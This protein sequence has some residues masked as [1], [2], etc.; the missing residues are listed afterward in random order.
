MFSDVLL[1]E[2]SFE[3]T[4]KKVR[5]TKQRETQTETLEF[6]ENETQT[7]VSTF[8]TTD[9]TDSEANTTPVPP[10]IEER[11]RRGE[12]WLSP[13]QVAASS[14]KKSSG[15]DDENDEIID[16]SF[17]DSEMLQF[18]ENVAPEMLAQ[19]EMNV[20]TSAFD[21]YHVSWEDSKDTVS[22]LHVLAPQMMEDNNLDLQVT[23]LCWNC[24]G[25]LLATA[26]GRI[27]CVGWCTE[28][29]Y[30]TIWNPMRDDLNEKKPE[31]TIE[32]DN[33]PL[34]LDFHPEEP[35]VLCGGTYNGEIFVWNVAN[36]NDNLIAQ[37]QSQLSG[38][39]VMH[40][41]PIQQVK[42][43]VNRKETKLK[44]V[45]V[46]VSGDGK[47][48]FWT[49]NNKM[50]FPIAG[51]EVLN[52]KSGPVGV[53]CIDVLST[54]G[55]SLS[56]SQEPPCLENTVIIGTDL[57]TVYKTNIKPVPIPDAGKKQ[58]VGKL[59][60]NDPT[61][62]KYET[63]TGPVQ[64]V[65]GNPFHRSLFLSCSCDGTVKFFNIVES[66]RV[67][68]VM[69]GSSIDSYI[70]S[71]QWSPVR[72]FVF[73]CAC[74]D[75]N[76][77]IYDLEAT[78]IKPAVTMQAGMHGAPVLSLA[79]NAAEHHL[80]ATGDAAGQVRIWQLSDT[81]STLSSHESTMLANKATAA[82][83]EAWHKH[84]GLQL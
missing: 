58:A 10:C 5:K 48:L 69:P 39:T 83:N 2:H 20:R 60:L 25:S 33:Y 51:N 19:L 43:F 27:D 14:P 78:N 34:C 8:Q 47:I 82:R 35:S 74:K 31:I 73:A 28:K 49:M 36:E 67:H 37:T 52:R 64:R 11:T 7:V 63:H 26:Y 41:D 21:G 79:F 1:E 77:Y 68:H 17:I 56:S 38:T 30:V 4:W 29:G 23:S 44:Y 65:S 71:A 61:A 22:T 66:G 55:R 59:V 70:Y 15:D 72:P 13:E 42:W 75:G 57:G 54:G 76:M 46:S 18:L 9:T 6:G 45:I 32:T 84:T 81:L 3:S 50:N 80:L 53:M 40:T 62:F 24:N 16:E 12:M